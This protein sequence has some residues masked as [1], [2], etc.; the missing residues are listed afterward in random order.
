MTDKIKEIDSY[1]EKLSSEDVKKLSNITN[2][3]H[4]NLINKGFVGIEGAKKNPTSGM[5]PSYVVEGYALTKEKLK[6]KVEKYK[7][8]CQNLD[9]F[10][11]KL[12]KYKS[13]YFVKFDNKSYGALAEQRYK[14][15]S[16]GRDGASFDLGNTENDQ[17]ILISKKAFDN[18]TTQLY[19]Y[20]YHEKEAKGYWDSLTD[21]EK[22]ET[23]ANKNFQ[24]SFANII[25]KKLLL[26]VR[27]VKGANIVINKKTKELKVV[28]IGVSIIHHKNVQALLPLNK[29]TKL[30][31]F[32][33]AY[34]EMQNF[35]KM[36]NKKVSE[37][38]INSLA[39]F[40]FMLSESRE[41]TSDSSNKFLVPG[42]SLFETNY[43]D[44]LDNSDFRINL[45]VSF[46]NSMLELI[47]NATKTL[48]NPECNKIERIVA[49]ETLG[50]ISN[51]VRL[52]NEA[53]ENNTIKD[54]E[55]GDDN[56]KDFNLIKK[57]V[58]EFLYDKKN[59]SSP[60]YD[61][62]V[63]TDFTSYKNS[64]FEKINDKKIE[65]KEAIKKGLP[66]LTEVQNSFLKKISF[67][68]ENNRSDSLI[69]GNDF[70]VEEQKKHI[71]SIINALDSIVPRGSKKDSIA[72]ISDVHGDLLSFLGSLY[73]SGAI[74]LKG[75]EFIYYDIHSSKYYKQSEYDKLLKTEKDRFVVIPAFSRNPDFKGKII[76]AG[77]MIDR[78]GDGLAICLIAERL[79]EEYNSYEPKERRVEIILGNHDITK[80]CNNTTD[81]HSANTKPIQLVMQRLIKKNLASSGVIIGT[82]ENPVLVSHAPFLESELIKEFEI[83]K[84]Y[85]EHKKGFLD[86]NNFKGLNHSSAGYGKLL[87]LF[88]ALELEFKEYPELEEIV[89]KHNF[90]SKESLIQ[91]VKKDFDTRSLISLRIILGNA[92]L[93]R[94]GTEFDLA[95]D[96]LDKS[97]NGKNSIFW[98]RA[99]GSSDSAVCDN[100]IGH[101]SA[102][103]PELLREAEGKKVLCI[104]SKRAS[105]NKDR[106]SSNSKISTL[107]L[108]DEKDGIKLDKGIF[109]AFEIKRDE[110][111]KLVGKLTEIKESIT[112][113]KIA[114]FKETLPKDPKPKELGHL[115]SEKSSK[116]EIPLK[117]IEKTSKSVVI[118]IP[119]TIMP[120]SIEKTSKSVVI[121]IPSQK[122]ISTNELKPLENTKSSNIY[123]N[124]E[125]T[126]LAF[127]RKTVDEKKIKLNFNIKDNGKV[128]SLKTAVILLK[129]RYKDKKI[130][131]KRLSE[132]LFNNLSDKDVDIASKELGIKGRERV[133]GYIAK[134]LTKT[135][136]D[137]TFVK[138]NIKREKK[139]KN[140]RIVIKPR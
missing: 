84:L 135:T 101:E 2:I 70:P 75:N 62:D 133:A 87:T 35:M 45:V 16:F 37:T 116:I 107:F 64:E 92:I 72:L 129:E 136:F 76:S 34:K 88:S 46:K 28:D 89:I 36:R 29:V 106:K 78:G 98:N 140:E 104:D 13:T 48:R 39:S 58:D 50:N 109:R 60:I 120:E 80:I 93:K 121:E 4:K 85:K 124:L 23:T 97:S 10:K 9:E 22:K 5:N 69:Y 47:G 63:K 40:I 61:D 6:R 56:Y 55:K 33:N 19:N 134:Y 73:D 90:D 26:N 74:I 68:A 66:Y 96:F 52:L 49:I 130:A 99:R 125:S 103:Y 11:N 54:L 94:S 117:P 57:E 114:D 20:N 132:I 127:K 17:T 113:K 15:L 27:D 14:L 1:V 111:R 82:K 91:R 51:V 67:R 18:E 30:E 105:T 95:G 126:R 25:N 137:R 77:D 38:A 43:F 119:K 122:T 42:G 32:L 81:N 3:N 112:K 102:E 53:V 21:K 131:K 24:E 86:I 8:K 44:L 118:E 110:N 83:F 31:D 115:E 59:N 71:D 12:E 108:E 139:E 65:K 7:E 138:E 123:D 128:I 41:H 100:I 79:A